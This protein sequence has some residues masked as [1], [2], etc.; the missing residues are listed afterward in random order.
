MRVGSTRDN[1]KRTTD[2]L[3]E[4]LLASTSA[5]EYLAYEA[6]NLEFRRLSDYV[7]DLLEEKGLSRAEVFRAG[8][9]NPTY[10]YNAFSGAKSRL[11]RNQVLMLAFGL[12]C[13]LAETQRLLRLA[14]VSELWPRIPRDAIIIRALEEGKTREET[15]EELYRLGEDTVLEA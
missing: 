7:S 3:L 11:G 9:I 4:Q 13:T 6:G 8:G 15:D 2:E 1:A 5:E 14:G 10:G 12:R